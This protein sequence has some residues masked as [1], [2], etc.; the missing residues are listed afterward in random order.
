MP[1]Q[2]LSQ[3]TGALAFTVFVLLF[4]YIVARILN[5]E[6]CRRHFLLFLSLIFNSELDRLLGNFEN[7]VTLAHF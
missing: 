4:W 1:I 3:I 7:G 6:Q 5:I 2:A